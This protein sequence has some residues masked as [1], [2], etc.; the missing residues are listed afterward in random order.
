MPPAKNIVFLRKP[1]QKE[2]QN[3]K[4]LR[5]IFFAKTKSM[6]LSKR[7]TSTDY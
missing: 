5:N 4:K 3:Q 6:R 1:I 7:T 2:K